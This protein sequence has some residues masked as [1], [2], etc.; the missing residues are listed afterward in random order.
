MLQQLSEPFD[1]HNSHPAA[2]ETCRYALSPLQAIAVTT[3]RQ[4]KL[5]LRDKVLLKGRMMQ[6]RPA[7]SQALALAQPQ[8]SGSGMGPG[9]AQHS[10]AVPK[11]KKK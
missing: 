7:A 10:G 3:K 4:M 5:V 11:A 8:L 9:C 2:L 1:P 6:V